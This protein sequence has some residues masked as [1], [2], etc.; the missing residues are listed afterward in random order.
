MS[1]VL[2]SYLEIQDA[3]ASDSTAGVTRAAQAI[4]K[5][6]AN[7]DASSVRDKQAA[8]HYKEI[9]ANIAEAANALAAATTLEEA[10][11]RFKALSQPMTM[12]ATMSKPAGINVMFCPGVKGS[13]LQKAGPVRNPYYGESML[14]CGQLVGGSEHGKP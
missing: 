10:R 11:S 6:V 2:A 8:H 12:W 9:P 7:V 1:P 3:L 14:R 13:W 5:V 4:A